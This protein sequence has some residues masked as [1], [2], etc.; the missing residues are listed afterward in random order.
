MSPIPFAFYSRT[1]IEDRFG[2]AKLL[3][4]TPFDPGTAWLLWQYS[5]RE[6]VDP[7][8]AAD[9]L[10]GF[11]KI[12]NRDR[13]KRD[14]W[15]GELQLVAIWGFGARGEHCLHGSISRAPSEADH[16]QAS[17]QSVHD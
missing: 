11:S 1:W 7:R 10:T 3:R 16:Y 13:F 17:P 9:Y 12:N 8:V 4:A 2:D 6:G 15:E 14:A 5:R